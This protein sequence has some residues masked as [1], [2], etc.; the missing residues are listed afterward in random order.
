MASKFNERILIDALY[1]LSPDSGS[2]ADYARA[3]LV[4]IVCGMMA[5]GWGWRE[6][7]AICSKLAP[8]NIIADCLPDSY[9]EDFKVFCNGIGPINYGMH[10]N[11]WC[12]SEGR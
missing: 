10:D 6:A 5:S 11:V 4:G 12:R 7:M 2:S 9:C 8:K 1:N 3:M